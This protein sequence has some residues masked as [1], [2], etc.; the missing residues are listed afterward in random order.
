MPAAAISARA[1]AQPHPS[2]LKPLR[3]GFFSAGFFESCPHGEVIEGIVKQLATARIHGP[4]G[5]GGAKLFEIIVLYDSVSWQG[6][7]KNGMSSVLEKA[8]DKVLAPLKCCHFKMTECTLQA[9]TLKVQG[10][11][12]MRKAI[13]QEKLDILVYVDTLTDLNTHLVQHARIAPIQV[14]YKD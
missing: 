12:A 1:L 3:V 11:D 8:A 6:P 10:V 14:S 7:R 5:R 4:T 2:V 13:S 9:V